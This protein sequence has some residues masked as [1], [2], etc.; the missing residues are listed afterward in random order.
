MQKQTN[1]DDFAEIWRKAEQRRT[2]EMTDWLKQLLKK[3]S[4]PKLR[5]A[6]SAR[7]WLRGPLTARHG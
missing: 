3:R 2:D 6:R 5:I 4:I 1:K 7:P